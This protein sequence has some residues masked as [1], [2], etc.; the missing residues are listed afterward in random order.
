MATISLHAPSGASAAKKL[1]NGLSAFFES[2]GKAFVV[3]A[4]RRS[5]IQELTRLQEKSDEELAEI[6]IKREEIAQHV[7]R[8][9]F[10]L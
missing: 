8:D 6:G 4:E 3:Y 1:G 9:L 2:V 10:Y 7:F 5:R